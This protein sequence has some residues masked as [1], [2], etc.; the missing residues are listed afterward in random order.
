[1]KTD[2]G[3]AV[4][5]KRDLAFSPTTLKRYLDILQALYTVFTV[6]PWHRNFARASLQTPKVDFF[7][8]SLMCG[9]DG[10]RLETT[11]A[12]MRL[13]HVHRLLHNAQGKSSLHSIRTKDDA[14]ADGMQRVG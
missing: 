14:G 3:S 12:A 7:D 2:R 6:H 8:T 4:L 10:I 5:R 9:D 1:M 11:V 13:I